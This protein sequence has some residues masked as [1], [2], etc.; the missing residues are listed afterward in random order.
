MVK[1]LHVRDSYRER[2]ESDSDAGRLGSSAMGWLRTAL[3][4][5]A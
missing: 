3:S 5:G 4:S 2:G 1:A